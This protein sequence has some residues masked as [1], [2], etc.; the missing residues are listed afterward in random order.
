MVVRIMLF[1]D[2]DDCILATPDFVCALMLYCQLQIC[3]RFRLFADVAW[4]IS[5]TVDNMLQ[6]C[7]YRC[8]MRHVQPVVAPTEIPNRR[9]ILVP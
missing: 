9:F 5:V 3:S 2:T 4:L 1:E 6:G 8:A 7:G